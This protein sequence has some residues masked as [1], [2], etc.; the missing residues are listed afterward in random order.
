MPARRRLARRHDENPLGNRAAN[1]TALALPMNRRSGDGSSPHRIRGRAVPAPGSWPRFTSGSWRC[2][3]TM[4]KSYPQSPDGTKP[5]VGIAGLS[6]RR[7]ATTGVRP[8]ARRGVAATPPAAA[9]TQR[10]RNGEAPWPVRRRRREGRPAASDRQ[11]VEFVRTGECGVSRACTRST[12]NTPI[13]GAARRCPAISASCSRVLM[14]SG[15]LIPDWN[16]SQSAHAA[17]APGSPASM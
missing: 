2:S 10:A 5:E 6:G 9:S 12:P 1:R 8:R 7:L 16:F 14:T 13:A 3:L 11:G 17:T 15:G 4:E